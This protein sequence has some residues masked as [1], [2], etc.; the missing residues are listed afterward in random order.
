MEFAPPFER[1]VRAFTKLPTIGRK[2]AQRLVFYLL[3]C[4]DEDIHELAESLIELKKKLSHCSICGSITEADPCP[5]CTSSRRDDSCLCVVGEPVD[6]FAIEKTSTFSG[7]YH[8][9]GGVLSPLDGIGPDQI[10]IRELLQRLDDG[11][12][13]EVIIA[14]NPTVEGETTAGYL[15]KLI[16]PKGISVSRIAYGIPVGGDL[17]YADEATLGKAFSGRQLIHPDKKE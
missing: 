9:L 3:N 8:V 6:V 2:T 5:L 7:R 10:R 15:A 4:S 14:T 16:E 1:L 11:K 12:V 13:K 17:E